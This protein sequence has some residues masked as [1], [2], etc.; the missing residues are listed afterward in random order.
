MQLHNETNV[1]SYRKEYL[2]GFNERSKVHQPY[3]RIVITLSSS[4]LKFAYLYSIWRTLHLLHGRGYG[5]SWQLMVMVRRRW[6]LLITTIGNDIVAP[7]LELLLLHHNSQHSLI[8]SI[9]IVS[10]YPICLFYSHQRN[11]ATDISHDYSR[12][13]EILSN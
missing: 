2:N 1:K 8:N 12:S 10:L 6:P 3:P 4:M 5:R 11:H 9:N 7:V 13:R